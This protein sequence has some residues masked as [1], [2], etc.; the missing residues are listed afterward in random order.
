MTI[1]FTTA[2][3]N[4]AGLLREYTAS[5]FGF[6]L[7]YGGSPALMTRAIRCCKRL[8]RLTGHDLLDVISTAAADWATAQ[9]QEDGQ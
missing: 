2:T 6:T 3:W 8:A 9:D 7:M 4:D 5:R 1:R